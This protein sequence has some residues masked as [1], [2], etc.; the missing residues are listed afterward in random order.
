M[1]MKSSILPSSS[2]WRKS[3]PLISMSPTFAVKTRAWSRPSSLPI[4]RTYRKSVKTRMTPRRIA[5]VMALPGY[6]RKA[7]GLVKTTFSA[8]R[9]SMAA[10]S[11]FS[12]ALRNGCM[13]RLP[14][15]LVD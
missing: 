4:S 12:T 11:R 10:W 3:Q 13:A 15:Q 8:S 9:A 2:K 1:T 7:T 14:M 6:G 5:A